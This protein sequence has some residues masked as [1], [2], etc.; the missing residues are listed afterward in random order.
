NRRERTFVGSVC[1]TCDEPLEHILRGEAI[2][3]LTCGHISHEACLHEYVRDGHSA[4]CPTCEAPL[5]FDTSRGGKV[6]YDSLR[7]LIRATQ[8]TIDQRRSSRPT[9]A[10]STTSS[11]SYTAENAAEVLPEAVSDRRSDGSTTRSLLVNGEDAAQSQDGMNMHSRNVSSIGSHGS[12]E[13]KQRRADAR[14]DHE[15]PAVEL[16]SDGRNDLDRF[17]VQEP[18]IVMRSEFPSITKSRYQQSLTCMVTIEV[19]ESSW[20]TLPD[21]NLISPSIQA[22]QEQL[23]LQPSPMPNLPAHTPS[24]QEGIEDLE[25]A[26]EELFQ[27]VDDWHGLDPNNFGKLKLRGSA[28]KVG[29]DRK[30]WQE[31]DC[32]L[33]S[34][35]LICVKEKKVSASA[36]HVWDGLEQSAPAARW[37]LKGSILIKKHL[38]E[39]AAVPDHDIL[40]LGL[41]V[42]QLPAFHL[43]FASRADL[44]IWSQALNSIDWEARF[45]LSKMDLDEIISEIE[46]NATKHHAETPQQTT[47]N[48]PVEEVPLKLKSPPLET[49]VGAHKALVSMRPLHSPM[50]IVVVFPISSAAHGF[51]ADILRDSLRF[52]L[53]LLGDRDRLAIITVG[54]DSGSKIL[55]PLTTKYSASWSSKLGQIQP[56]EQQDTVPDIIEGANAAVD[57]LMRRRLSNPIAQVFLLSDVGSAAA[58]T[59]IDLLTARADTGN[60]GIYTF[61]LGVTHT[62]DALLRVSER[63]RASYTYVKEWHMLRDCLAGCV[64]S[65]QSI[66][67]QNVKLRLRLPDGSPAKFVKVSGALESAKNVPGRSVEVA[68]GDLRYGDRRNV[69]VQLIIQPERITEAVLSDHFESMVS[70]LPGMSP[71]E[72]PENRSALAE[73]VLLLEAD[74]DWGDLTRDGSRVQLPEH[75]TLAVNRLPS[76]PFHEFHLPNRP[77]TPSTPPHPYIVQRRL[78]LLTSDMLSRALQLIDQG[79]S[80]RATHLLSETRT[81]LQGLGK[82]NISSLPSP[83]PSVALPPTPKTPTKGSPIIAPL[84]APSVSFDP[85]MMAILDSELNSNLDWIAHPDIF[86][87][88]PRKAILQSIGVISTQRGFT[89]RTPTEALCAARISGVQHALKQSRAW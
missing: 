63:T 18:T 48:S 40:T 37:V 73:E 59:S 76:S 19:A 84:S 28:I 78:E 55:A 64:G 57:I 10:Q 22:K 67:H 81:I 34:E 38:E 60:I 20:P 17:P 6:D 12:T 44:E 16:P 88:D 45:S 43:L 74:L 30:V 79:Q 32:Y 62:P 3:Q 41:S 61:G 50:D 14:S 29:K 25:R 85:A 33:F 56:L 49:A 31:L 4:V 69:L 77:R 65:L 1:A 42:P 24:V 8:D 11:V 36:C 70:N 82:V 13:P 87:R 23:S 66:S 35:M 53:S 83:P 7:K 27:R 47:A 75:S 89:L 15:L 58:E 51:K 46:N 80:A 21:S 2:L 68:L 39:V 26:R 72:P 71:I 9:Q 54:D 5:D 52:L 86:A